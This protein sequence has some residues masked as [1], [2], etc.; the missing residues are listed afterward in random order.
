MFQ[1]RILAALL[2]SAV[3]YAPSVGFGQE[4]ECPDPFAA[5]QLRVDLGPQFPNGWTIADD[6][7]Q[8]L[9]VD[10]RGFVSLDLPLIVDGGPQAL[11]TVA[12]ARAV[13]APYWADVAACDPDGQP[14]PNGCAPLTV[15]GRV[16]TWSDHDGVHVDWVGVKGACGPGVPEAT[17]GMSI[18]A[19]RDPGTA[20][21]TFR[22][23]ALEWSAVDGRAQARAGIALAGAGAAFELL[24]ARDG[25][26]KYAQRLVEGGSEVVDREV[27]TGV[28]VLDVGPDGRVTGEGERPGQFDGVRSADN[29]PWTFNPLQGDNDRDGEGDACDNNDDND[30]FDDPDDNCQ[31][32]PND[33]QRDHDGDGRGDAC[34]WDDD[35]DKVP[36]VIDN[37]RGRAN[38]AQGDVDGD[39]RGDLCEID[40]DGDGRVPFSPVLGIA[41]DGCPWVADQPGNDA[42]RDGIEDACDARPKAHCGAFCRLDYDA[43]GDG[44]PDV[45]DICPH[46]ADRDQA[47]LD[48]DRIGDACD[49]DANGNGR[50]DVLEGI[51][52]DGVCFDASVLV[53]APLGAL[54]IMDA[55]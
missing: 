17:F 8:A 2:S 15:Q 25:A 55:E 18:S 4:G 23:D 41:A 26:G 31:W 28:W 42:D 40:I 3:F 19:G 52:S 30:R 29:C 24:D 13:I 39:R 10:P 37:C 27:V 50:P 47:D 22:Y 1:S 9:I 35:N 38:P 49:P 54:L 6:T 36:D 7:Y 44:V 45:I 46:A 34:D 21:I 5:A 32:T 14:D 48:G 12:D 11:E 51:C 20:R 43:D 53:P 33:D 16:N